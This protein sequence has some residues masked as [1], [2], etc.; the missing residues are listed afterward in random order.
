[1]FLWFSSNR[2][3]SLT[4]ETHQ[5]AAGKCFRIVLWLKMES[6]K[7]GRHLTLDKRTERTTASMA[8][9]VKRRGGP[10]DQ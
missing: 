5:I 3:Y 2:K 4:L 7:N 8:R 10:E 1:M 6:S 9:V